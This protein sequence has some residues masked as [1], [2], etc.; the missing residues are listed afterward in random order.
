MDSDR[1]TW[2]ATLDV[3][4]KAVLVGVQLATRAMKPGDNGET[5]AVG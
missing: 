3:N 5:P 2:E 4:L 1:G